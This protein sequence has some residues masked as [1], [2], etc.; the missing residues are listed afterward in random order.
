MLRGACLFQGKK[1]D[2]WDFHV[3]SLTKRDKGWEECGEQ[4]WYLSLFVRVYECVAVRW[5]MCVYLHEGEVQLT[6]KE[7][8]VS[9]QSTSRDPGSTA[10]DNL[11]ITQ[12]TTTI[13]AEYLMTNK[14][15]QS[16]PPALFLCHQPSSISLFSWQ[17][18]DW[19]MLL[20]WHQN[21]KSVNHDAAGKTVHCWASSINLRRESRHVH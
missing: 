15:L 21:M 18:T 8:R 17:G 6:C 11:Q 4:T 5:W 16:F 19:R 9:A 2:W 10:E 7:G 20:L 12:D 3:L 1:R 13:T 14:I